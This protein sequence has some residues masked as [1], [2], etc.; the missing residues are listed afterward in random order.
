MFCS[1]FIIY[2][3]YALLVLMVC[4]AKN[5]NI[6][7][8]FVVVFYVYFIELEML[9]YNFFLFWNATK[10]CDYNK[11]NYYR[12]SVVLVASNNANEWFFYCRYSDANQ[13][14]F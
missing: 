11:F 8:R 12:L 10:W 4:D 7:F 13:D 9:W 6:L 1:V 5:V 3:G 2:N 14:V